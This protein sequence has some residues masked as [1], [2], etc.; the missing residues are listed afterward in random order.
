MVV[1]V[2]IFLSLGILTGQLIKHHDVL[3]S[4]FF[5]S[6][7]YVYLTQ[8][9]QLL[10]STNEVEAKKIGWN[11]LLPEEEKRELHKYQKPL[12]L[13]FAEQLALSIKASADQSYQAA[14][15]SMNTV[16][17][18]NEQYVSISGFVVPL[19]VTS[20]QKVTSFFF[21]PYYGACL[22]YPPPP[23]N[24]MI[25]VSLPDGVA[26]I[27]MEQAYTLTGVL[28]QGLFED[29]MGTSAYV[30]DLVSMAPFDEQPDDVR[31]H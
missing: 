24:Q 11:S 13:D 22:H 3:A 31:Q 14:L 1:V 28:S 26:D 25:F 4:G 18:H 10:N 6:H 17:V 23:P 15:Y 19:E 9:P 5:S 30:M 21:V 2:V 7:P 12:G 8:D 20:N 27:N 29:P 16:D